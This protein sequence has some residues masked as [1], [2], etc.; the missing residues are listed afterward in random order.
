M[1]NATGLKFNTGNLPVDTLEVHFPQAYK[2]LNEMKATYKK[3]DDSGFRDM[4][5]E[6]YEAWLHSI[7]EEK[8]K[9][10]HDNTYNKALQIIR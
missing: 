10:E 2:L 4:P 1:R 6:A 3:I 7:N 9:R 5:Q 8:E